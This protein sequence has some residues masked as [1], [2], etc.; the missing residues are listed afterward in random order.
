MCFRLKTLPQSKVNVLI[1]QI[2]D[3]F[4]SESF[5]DLPQPLDCHNIQVQHIGRLCLQ[6]YTIYTIEFLSIEIESI[7]IQYPINGGQTSLF[8]CRYIWNFAIANDTKLL[9]N[10]PAMAAR[11]LR[12]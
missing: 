3:P 6:F 9:R 7:F 8:A 10:R 5:S 12:E 2:I 1:K 4:K 11:Q